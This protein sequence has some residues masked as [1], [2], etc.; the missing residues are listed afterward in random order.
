MD[1]NDNNKKDRK[2]EKKKGNVVLKTLKILLIVIIMLG[3]IGGGVVAGAVISILTDVPD[4]DPAN[5]N[6]SLD[7]T[8]TIYASN[9]ELIEKIQAPEF[10]TVVALDRMPKHLQEAFIAI[11]DERFTFKRINPGMLTIRLGLHC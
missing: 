6:T 4:I 11:E 3:I 5:V 10:R 2:K 8:S 7:Q 1:N 9:G